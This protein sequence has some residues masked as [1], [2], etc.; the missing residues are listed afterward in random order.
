MEEHFSPL[1]SAYRKNYSSQHVI[2]R[3]P[4]GWRKKLDD[5]LVVGAVSADMS[6]AYD[7]ILHD[8]LIAKLAAYGF[9]EEALMYILS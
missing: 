4:E 3:L 6:K 7:C 5:N 9:S 1:I 2:I 8:L